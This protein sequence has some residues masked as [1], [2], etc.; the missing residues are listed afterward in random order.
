[1]DAHPVFAINT[2]FRI[3]GLDIT[4]LFPIIFVSFIMLNLFKAVMNGILAVVGTALVF[5]LLCSAFKF[6]RSRVQSNFYTHLPFW[7]LQPNR[8][9]VA[10]DIYHVPVTLEPLKP[11]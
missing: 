8:F 4:E 1:M 11:R 3:M 5:F 6:L 2:P 7:L 9:H 10:K